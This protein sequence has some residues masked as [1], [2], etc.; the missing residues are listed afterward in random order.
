[1]LK[2][3]KEKDKKIRNEMKQVTDNVKLMHFWKHF[4]II[5]NMKKKKLIHPQIK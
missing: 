2:L 5:E 1:M 4:A 3:K